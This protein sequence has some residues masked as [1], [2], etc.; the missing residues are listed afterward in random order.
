MGWQHSIVLLRKQDLSTAVGAFT[1]W[2]LLDAAGSSLLARE[3]IP[4]AAVVLFGA[5]ITLSC[6]SL[7]FDRSS[8]AE[9]NVESH[10]L[11]GIA[12]DDGLLSQS[13]S[14]STSESQKSSWARWP[15]I[16]GLAIPLRI[17]AFETVRR[18][19]QCRTRGIE[20]SS[21]NFS[22]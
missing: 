5:G 1:L 9:K 16:L 11:R 22:I 21:S 12:A 4:S 15:L 7:F 10:D 18:N 17:V 14:A 8:T 13:L 20:V 3:P 2:H 19:S 6:I